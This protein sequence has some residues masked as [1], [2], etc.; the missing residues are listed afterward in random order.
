[1]ADQVSL[2]GSL[3]AG[4]PLASAAVP[5]SQPV[6]EKPPIAKPADPQIPGSPAGGQDASAGAVHSAAEAFGA[7]LQ[8]HQ[9][10]LVFQVD[11]TTGETVFR[12]VNTKTQEVI[13]Q[14]PSE[15]ILVMAQKLRELDHS[16]GA[17]G[18][19]VDKVG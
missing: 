1:M 2:S 11:Q 17:S 14:V 19:L 16:K 9:Q 4:V 10:E 18:V 8:Q 3:A 7:Y 5:R 12:I 15:D 6:P 13:R